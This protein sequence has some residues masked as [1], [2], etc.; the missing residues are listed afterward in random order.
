[1]IATYRILMDV[2]VFFNCPRSLVIQVCRLLVLHTK[3]FWRHSLRLVYVLKFRGAKAGIIDPQ[4][5]PRAI[6]TIK[7]T[8]NKQKTQCQKSPRT[9]KQKPQINPNMSSDN[10]PIWANSTKYS[11]DCQPLSVCSINC[12]S[13]QPARVP[14]M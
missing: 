3:P 10:N 6:F 9:Q 8:F 13:W 5:S 4:V 1:M 2:V 12:S 14:S 11:S 7:K